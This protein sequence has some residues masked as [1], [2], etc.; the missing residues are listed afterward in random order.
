MYPQQPQPVYYGS[1]YSGCLKFILYA[2]SFLI[3]LAGVIIG[4][5]FLSRPDPE[6]KSM[7][8]TCLILGIVS[9]VLSCCLAIVFGIAPAFIIPFLD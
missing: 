9:F 2:I 5:I 6:S 3:P 7:G 4:V 8:Q 1:Q